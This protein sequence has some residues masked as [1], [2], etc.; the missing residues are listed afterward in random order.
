MSTLFEHPHRRLNLL[1]NEW[2]QVS[3]HRTKRPW[4]GKQE[5]VPG[6]GRPAYDPTCY[7]CPGNVRATAEQQN[8]PYIQPIVFDNDFSALLP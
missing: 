2:I 5:S 4:Q 6:A 8:P 7:L 1:T 3:P